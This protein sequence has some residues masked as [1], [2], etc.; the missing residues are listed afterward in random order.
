MNGGTIAADGA[1]GGSGGG[2]FLH[3]DSISLAG[4]DV[5]DVR[6]ATG[7]GDGDSADCRLS[8]HESRH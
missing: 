6:G 7:G 5:L 4:S 3:A 2:N 8:L 1:G